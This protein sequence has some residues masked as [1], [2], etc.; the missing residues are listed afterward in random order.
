MQTLSKHG[1]VFLNR[2]EFDIRLRQHLSGYY[3]FLGKSLI[4]GRDQMFWTYHK[5]KLSEAGVGFKSIRVARGALA[6]LSEAALNPK[7]SVEKLLRR[8][9]NGNPTSEPLAASGMQDWVASG[10]HVRGRR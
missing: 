1:P 10:G 6:T 5:T 4:L 3:N 2:E 8:L 9:K 7:S